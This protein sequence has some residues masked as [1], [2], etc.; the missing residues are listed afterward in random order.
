MADDKAKVG[1]VKYV[2]QVRQEGRKVV[3]PTPRETMITTVMVLIVMV[4]FG[5]FFFFVDWLT[6]NGTQL[7]LGIGSNSGPGTGG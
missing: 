3:W 4:M 7:L 5:I 1:P 6:A 2:A